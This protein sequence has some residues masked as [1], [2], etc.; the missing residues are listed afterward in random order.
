MASAVL[1]LGACSAPSPDA[2]VVDRGPTST[3]AD[4]GAAPPPA[5]APPAGGVEDPQGPAD[6]AT[7]ASLTAWASCDDGFECATLTVPR[8]WDDVDGPTL[9][10]A[11]VRRQATGER[12][13]SLVLE[14]RPARVCRLDGRSA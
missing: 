13:G 6:P 9:D 2:T 4:G 8:R 10:L 1:L 3:A 5:E 12:I 7:H 11:V 14:T